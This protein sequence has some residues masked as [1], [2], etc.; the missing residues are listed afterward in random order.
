MRLNNRLTILQFMEIG[1]DEGLEYEIDESS[2]DE[3]FVYISSNTLLGLAAA[4]EEV[5]MWDDE[6]GQWNCT[7]EENMN[8]DE[9][10]DDDDISKYTHIMVL[11]EYE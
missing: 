5:H 4:I 7:P 10:A 11:H 8:I 6:K 1:S 9:F 2:R 3:G